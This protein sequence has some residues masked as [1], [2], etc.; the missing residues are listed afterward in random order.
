[1]A[2]LLLNSISGDIMKCPFLEEIMVA[3]CNACKVKK[4]VPKNNFGIHNACEGRFEECEVYK[5]FIAHNEHKKEVIMAPEASSDVRASKDLKPCIW[6]K[7]G[8]IEY[9]MCQHNYDCKN[10]E[11]DRALTQGGAES[12]MVVQAIEKLRQQPATERKCRYMLT[13]DF[14][15][16][17][18]P[19]NYECWHCPVDQYIQ[20]TLDDNPM[21]QKRRKR[22]AAQVK[23]VK[24]FTINEDLAY[25]PN[26]IW[27]KV[28]GDELT[29]GVD[30]FATRLLGSVDTIL[31]P[32]DNTVSKDQACW[33][34]GRHGRMVSMTLPVD[35]EIIHRN[36]LVQSDPAL[37]NKE[38]Y[39]NGWL[40]KIRASKDMPGMMKGSEVSG[41]IEKEFEKLHNE[42]AES[43]GVTITD[44][45]ELVE[46]VHDRLSEEDWHRLVSQFVW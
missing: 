27:V 25:L 22:M 7:A 33:H 40:L 14:S 44:G 19:N 34:I 32:V 20:D 41:W 24:G 3:F 2:R 12:S 39:N 15:Y 17:L 30:E 10:C 28:E 29:V 6:M 23:K 16:K 1:M 45:G 42:Y 43:T 37:I 38:P 13:G 5:E 36:D 18:C 11:F 8:V 9:R 46:N 31:L 4:M 35:G 26:H 21:L